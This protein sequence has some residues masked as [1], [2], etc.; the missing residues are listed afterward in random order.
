M[1]SLS[2]V[3]DNPYF[4]RC[5]LGA[6]GYFKGLLRSSRRVTGRASIDLVQTCVPRRE[7]GVCNLSGGAADG[8]SRRHDGL[9]QQVG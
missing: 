7:P 9:R 6:N 2:L 1:K 8:Y 3:L 5:A 4:Y